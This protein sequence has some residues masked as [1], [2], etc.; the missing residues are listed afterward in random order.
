MANRR[1]AVEL[2]RRR[3][4]VAG[5]NKA[6]I[7]NNTESIIVAELPWGALKIVPNTGLDF[8]VLPAKFSASTLML[9]LFSVFERKIN[10]VCNEESLDKPLNKT[11][12]RGEDVYLDN[13]L[14][15]LNGICE[16]CLPSVLSALI[17]WYESQ[18]KVSLSESGETRDRSVKKTLAAS[19][20][21][22]VALI[23]VLPQ[24][25][26]HPTDCEQPVQFIINTS[27]NQISYRDP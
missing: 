4:D 11:L 18:Q 24:I 16:M 17:K 6:N 12:R 22:C 27:F 2:F 21:F 5:S 7:S 20:L 23:E 13:L 15:T 25:H 8:G 14:R 26:F 1:T 10:L 19:Y 3:S 9:E